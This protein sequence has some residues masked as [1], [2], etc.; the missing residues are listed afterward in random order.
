MAE[1]ITDKME[2]N[3]SGLIY[4]YPIMDD[5]G[6]FG[7]RDVDTKE[8]VFYGKN[9]TEA[10]A[11]AVEDLITLAYCT[12]DLSESEPIIKKI[13]SFVAGIYPGSKVENDLFYE[14]HER[15]KIHFVHAQK[16]NVLAL[17]YMAAALFTQTQKLLKAADYKTYIEDIEYYKA[18]LARICFLYSARRSTDTYLEIVEKGFRMVSSFEYVIPKRI[19]AHKVFADIGNNDG[20]SIAAWAIPYY[21]MDE[22]LKKK[23]EGN[24]L[25]FEDQFKKYRE[26]KM[27]LDY[28]HENVTARR[29]DGLIFEKDI[30]TYSENTRKCLSEG[31]NAF[32]PELAYMYALFNDDTPL[33]IKCLDKIPMPIDPGDEKIMPDTYK[34]D[35]VMGEKLFLMEEI[36]KE[37]KKKKI[38]KYAK[39]TFKV[40]I[41]AI[42][43]FGII[44][45]FMLTQEQR[46]ILVACVFG[47]IVGLTVLYYCILGFIDWLK[48]DRRYYWGSNGV[49]YWTDIDSKK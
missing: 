7:K 3:L 32:W 35:G 17:R 10:K 14:A 11:L 25:L 48:K 40:L 38:K 37:E 31:S 22:L 24:Y 44:R 47:A 27:L 26:E 45:F 43:I 15:L 30:D 8:E 19:I 13:A 46:I 29:K 49:Y 42:I 18:E 33:M 12:K 28:F 16:G 1:M 2:N 41:A 6:N 20:Q 23:K 4:C 39:L 5:D 34:E 36:E 21:F 9:G